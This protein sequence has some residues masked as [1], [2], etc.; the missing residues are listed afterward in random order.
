M[1]DGLKF[2]HFVIIHD[3]SKGHREGYFG[4][5]NMYLPYFTLE[6]ANLSQLDLLF[7]RQK[8]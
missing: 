2:C 6:T 8:K 1:N 4:L 7:Q 5:T 3:F